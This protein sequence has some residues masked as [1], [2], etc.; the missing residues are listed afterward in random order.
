MKVLVNRSLLKTGMMKKKTEYILDV[1]AELT[2]EEQTLLEQV[3][4]GD[5]IL[6]EWNPSWNPD[7]D[8][9]MTVDSMVS[10]ESINCA[11]FVDLVNTEEEVKDACRTLVILLD[12]AKSFGEEEVFDFS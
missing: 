7:I 6:H 3:E 9:T 1:R 10:G 4:A 8:M 2:P 12:R 5:T 11:S